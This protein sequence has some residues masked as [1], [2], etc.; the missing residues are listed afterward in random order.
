LP[1]DL[2]APYSLIA[3]G[4]TRQMRILKDAPVSI[5][6]RRILLLSYHFPPAETAGALRWQKLA[7]PLAAAG[8]TLDVVTRDLEEVSNSGR[9]ALVSLPTETRVFVVFEGRYVRVS[10]Q[11]HSPDISRSF[12]RS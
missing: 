6:R 10:I 1:D 9:R 4:L 8:W 2:A 7:T 11:R 12:V 3:R 5:D